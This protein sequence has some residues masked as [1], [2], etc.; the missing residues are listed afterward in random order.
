[1]E[2][3]I[4]EVYRA[5]TESERAEGL[6]WY[7]AARTFATG[8]ADRYGITLDAAAGIVAALSPRRP[9]ADNMAAA[10]TLCRTGDVG[11]LSLFVNRAKAIRDGAAPL[12]V[13]RGPKVR[14]FYAAI[15]GDGD[16]VCIDRH[17]FDVAYGA[18]TDDKTRKQL[19]RVGEYARFADAYRAAAETAG[20]TAAAMQATTWVVW[21][22][23]KAAA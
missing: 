8:L 15:M 5:A 20:T 19:D 18:A 4:L 3:N 22:N 14:A 16:A 2:E 21:R 1:M 10:D 7:S 11:G 6:D 17:A 9:W 12:D 23:R 13:L